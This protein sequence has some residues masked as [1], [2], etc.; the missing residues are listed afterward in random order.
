MQARKPTV[1]RFL[2][3]GI[4][5]VGGKQNPRLKFPI[6]SYSILF[7][8]IPRVS[9]QVRALRRSGTENGIHISSTRISRDFFVTSWCWRLQ[10]CYASDVVVPSSTRSNE[11]QAAGGICNP[12][13]LSIEPPDEPGHRLIGTR[14]NPL[15]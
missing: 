11:C 1:E 14:H 7:Y 8:P 13:P 10:I 2:R 6:L 4:L 5:P 3:A 9:S 12:G 15:I